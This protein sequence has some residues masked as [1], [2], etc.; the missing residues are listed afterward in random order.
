MKFRFQCFI[1]YIL[2]VVSVT[3]QQLSG[4][5][6]TETLRPTKLKNVNSL[7][8]YKE[9][10]LILTQCHCCHYYP[11]LTDD[12]REAESFSLAIAICANG[13]LDIRHVRHQSP[14]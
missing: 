8:P 14:C 4:V 3:L 13:E 1:I 10:L 9:I 5:V 2:S 7:A 11:H 12:E 6:E